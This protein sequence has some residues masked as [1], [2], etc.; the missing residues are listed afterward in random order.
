[1]RR[2]ALRTVLCLTHILRT[3]EPPALLTI[4]CAAGRGAEPTLA[5]FALPAVIETGD[6]LTVHA[7]NH[8]I[9]TK[10]SFTTAALR[11]R[12]EHADRA[13]TI[14]A[15]DLAGR[16]NQMPSGAKLQRIFA[17]R[18]AAIDA[19]AQRRCWGG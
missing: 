3:N 6:A 2:A 7:L 4:L 9:F 16:A 11:Q 15:S 8:T 5:E 17:R 14:R 1:M 19:E 13:A 18:L 10:V 12:T